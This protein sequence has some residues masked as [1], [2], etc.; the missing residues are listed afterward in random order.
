MTKIPHTFHHRDR[1]VKVT[2]REDLEH[3]TIDMEMTQHRRMVLSSFSTS[4]SRG[5]HMI[6]AMR[7]TFCSA[8]GG[9][10]EEMILPESI[11]V[12]VRGPIEIGDDELEAIRSEV[13]EK[14]ESYR[15]SH[16][17]D[18]GDGY[19]Y[20]DDYACDERDQATGVARC[21]EQKL[22]PK[23]GRR[24]APYT[25]LRLGRR[26][27]VIAPEVLEEAAAQNEALCAAL[28][29]RPDNTGDE[30]THER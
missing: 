21:G 12:I 14:V 6:P 2:T 27:A 8:C 3:D 16:Y 30:I 20:A 22:L 29:W 19:G 9:R 1:S 7:T 17:E 25:L 26:V 5:Q 4:N 18:D 13:K 10:S 15:Y 23:E 28:G 11:S 24:P